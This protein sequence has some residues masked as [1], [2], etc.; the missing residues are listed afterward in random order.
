MSEI[1]ETVL[2]KVPGRKRLLRAEFN[3][4]KLEISFLGDGRLHILYFER[5]DGIDYLCRTFSASS[6]LTAQF[7]NHWPQELSTLVAKLAN[8]YDEKIGK[9]CLGMMIPIE[10]KKILGNIHRLVWKTDS[11]PFPC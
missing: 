7:V 8:F 11:M 10:L 6:V 3:G 5:R 1:T 4:G 2:L 9:S